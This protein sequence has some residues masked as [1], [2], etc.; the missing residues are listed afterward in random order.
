MTTTPFILDQIQIGGYV[1][2]VRLVWIV[3]LDDTTSVKLSI[4][5]QMPYIPA[6]GSVVEI[7]PAHMTIHGL[8]YIARSQSTYIVCKTFQADDKAHYTE[9]VKSLIDCGFDKHD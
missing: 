7:G 5:L 3:K 1:F 6:K 4:C 9:F 2:E 8:L